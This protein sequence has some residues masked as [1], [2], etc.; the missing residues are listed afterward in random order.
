MVEVAVERKNNAENAKK[1]VGFLLTLHSYF[2]LL[3]ARDPLLFIELKKGHLVFI[4][5][6]F[7]LLIQ[8]RRISI[9]GLKSS[10][11]AVKIWLLKAD[12]VS[13]YGVT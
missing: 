6:Q 9:V 8:S 11:R 12:R 1:K 5:D 4:R 7:W 13:L 2:L 3:N 10:S